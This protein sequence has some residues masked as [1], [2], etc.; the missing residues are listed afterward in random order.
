M[1]E[2]MDNY[3][4]IA[5]LEKR[6][7]RRIPSFSWTYLESGTGDDVARD[8]NLEALRQIQFKPQFLKGP[9]VPDIATTLFGVRYDAPIGI[10][11]VGLTGLIWPG[12]DEALATTAAT[13][14]IPYVMSTVATTSP[15]LAGQRARGMGWFQL[16]PPREKDL[17][18]DLIDRAHAAGLTT[19]GHRRCA[20]P[21]SSRT[22]AKGSD[23]GTA[24]DRTSTDRT[25]GDASGVGARNA[26]SWPTEFCWSRKVPRRG[27]DE[28]HGGLCR[29]QTRGNPV[30][31]LPRDTSP[32]ME[33][34]T[35]RQG[36]PRS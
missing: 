23:P 1:A 14:Q 19:R 25:I 22:S 29:R 2:L 17:R 26:T 30:V 4:S 36:H 35:R 15:E 18:R 16:Y 24:R 31:G 9:L 10:A 11:P 21:E 20:E 12:A 33:R 28:I 7:R 13:N 6:A 32:R 27:N 34:A 5:D 3:P 8:H